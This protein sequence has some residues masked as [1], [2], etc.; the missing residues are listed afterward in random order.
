MSFGIGTRTAIDVGLGG[1]VAFKTDPWGGSV[2][3]NAAAAYSMRIPAGSTYSGPL[4][5]VRRSSDNAEQDIYAT[6]LPDSNGNRFVDTTALLAFV[7]VN[8]GFATTWYDQSG[9]GYHA[10]Q[11]TA[12]LQPRIV[13]AGV[14]DTLN[15]SPA[16]V[17]TTN[18][19]FLTAS[20]VP[21]NSDLTMNFVG[22]SAVTNGDVFG[23]SVSPTGVVFVS[24]NIA[25]IN[26]A[27]P[28]SGDSRI[29]TFTV[30]QKA[31]SSDLNLYYSGVSGAL[32]NAPYTEFRQSSFGFNFFVDSVTSVPGNLTE[33]IC[34]LSVID[35]TTRQTLERSQGTAFNITVA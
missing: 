29:K 33:F 9:S 31:S 7:G 13:N 8:S 34:F 2:F 18:Q 35:A 22:T 27:V 10:T 3:A 5:R 23:W 20:N 6:S 24:P 4:L 15:N 25:Q 16:L 21:S 14:V 17:S 26:F 30:D 19:T 28:A 32:V 12:S 11:A 1:I